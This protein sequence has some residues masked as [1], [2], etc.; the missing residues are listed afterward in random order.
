MD[1]LAISAV[2]CPLR[3]SL[4]LLRGGKSRPPRGSS[5]SSRG[6]RNALASAPRLRDQ[7]VKVAVSGKKDGHNQL[8]RDQ[9]ANLCRS[10]SDAQPNEAEVSRVSGRALPPQ[11][12]C[13][14]TQ[15]FA[16]DSVLLPCQPVSLSV[17]VYLLASLGILHAVGRNDLR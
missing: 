1:D 10:G 17:P 15:S 14:P 4:S 9:P 12:T 6:A 7:R 2:L 16:L 3:S 11:T 8:S 5:P 13:T